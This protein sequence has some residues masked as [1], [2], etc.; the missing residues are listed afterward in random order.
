MSPIP[1]IATVPR[2][3]ATAVPSTVARSSAMAR[4]VTAAC[5]GAVLLALVLLNLTQLAR[6]LDRDEGAFLT[7]AQEILHGHVPYRDVFD[8]KGPGI[9]Y[10]TAGMLSLCRT[11]PALA[12]VEVGRVLALVANLLTAY[13][14][15]LLGTRWWREAVGL[16]AACLWLLSL[17][18][19]QGD[20][21]LTEPFAVVAVVWAVVVASRRADAAGVAAAG[22]AVALGSLFKQT[23]VLSLPAVLLV[24]LSTA[25]VLSSE[26]GAV[27]RA[28]RLALPLLAGFCAV[29]LAA[30]A[31]FALQGALAPM[32]VDVVWTSLAHYPGDPPANILRVVTFDVFI[33]PLMWIAAGA[34]LIGAW[35]AGWRHRARPGGT[36]HRPVGALALAL[37]LNLT[38]FLSHAYSHYWVQVVPWLALLAAPA[39][40]SRFEVH[41]VTA[42][43]RTT[44]VGLW[45]AFGNLGLACAALVAVAMPVIWADGAWS[46]RAQFGEEGRA[47]LAEE[48]RAAA[49]IERYTP[50]GAKLLVAPAAPEL[51]FVAHRPP[52]TP[53]IYLL[54]VNLSTGTLAQALDDVSRQRFD[55]IVWVPKPDT[56]YEQQADAT[57]QRAIAE[58]YVVA[59]ANPRHTLVI[60]KRAAI[61]P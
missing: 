30:C 29:W 49:S 12:Q 47:E 19:F 45:R 43:G 61:I 46:G 44:S 54:P 34:T 38:P 56:P 23:A 60:Y 52:S 11:L 40:V 58:R 22:T 6:P 20:L 25:G 3:E 32:V 53:Y 2:A 21:L 59:Y 55:V 51:Y 1:E 37:A 42:S 15:Y 27:R 31:F 26:R 14:L 7:I 41:D 24:A 28:V 48:G 57:L 35:R 18:L 17:P 39:I 4:L 8:H 50:P 13:G 36:A 9:Y 33:S 16:V 5:V 10:L